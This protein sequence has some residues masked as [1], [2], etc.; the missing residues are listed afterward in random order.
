MIGEGN[1]GLSGA[2]LTEHANRYGA[3]QSESAVPLG[4][5]ARE[6]RGPEG[7][8]PAR[9][10]WRLIDVVD[11]QLR[12][13]QDDAIVRVERQWVVDQASVHIDAI[14]AIQVLHG[15]VAWSDVDAGVFSG[16]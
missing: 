15:D 4:C 16:H 12:R 3:E 13:S 14:R 8:A 7:R 5:C 9:T 6:S 11:G 10:S 2:P 1:L